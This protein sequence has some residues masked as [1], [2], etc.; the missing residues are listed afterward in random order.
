MRTLRK[1]KP[2]RL[3]KPRRVLVAVIA[4]FAVSL[5]GGCTFLP[6]PQGAAPLRYRDAI[7]TNLTETDGITYGSAP[8]ASG[9]PVT[10]TLDMYRPTGDT[11][12]S[13]PAIVLV[14]GGG[15]SGGN[16]K[17]GAMVKMA[18]AFAQ[19]GYVAV[20]INYRLL[21]NGEKCGVEDTV[22]QN[23]LTAALAAQH[24][25]QAAVRWLRANAGTYRVDP[26]RIAI[27]GGSA[28]AAT[29]L[30]VAVNSTDPGDSGNPGYSSKVGAAISISGEIPHSLAPQFLDKNDSPVIMFHGT[31]DT[32]VPYS[33]AV[34][35]AAD[36]DNAGIP[37]VF[38]SLEGGG[39]VP[40]ATFG[41]QI[42]SQSVYF[43]YY[44]LDL[45]HA[46]GQPASA[47]R[48][49]ESQIEQYPSV[50]RQLKNRHIPAR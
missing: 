40:M 17:N 22:S 50:A 43:S 2:L 4:V 6:A 16:S 38:E 8:D 48:A 47:A 19:R 41:D 39:H 34:Q 46:A 1:P 25:A 14:H 27:G 5:L 31:A 24:D 49:L 45:A 29:A 20:S 11:Q 42:I 32:V 35:T 13:R 9:N 33:F 7:F 3:A 28:G 21:N 26:T 23:C 12:T 18:K 36:L 30:A 44:L 10:L 37:V 15:F